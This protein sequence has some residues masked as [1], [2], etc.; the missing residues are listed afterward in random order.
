LD[1][2]LRTTTA[3][4]AAVVTAAQAPTNLTTVFY[5]NSSVRVSFTLPRNYYSSTYYYQLNTSAAGVTTSASGQSAALTT[6]NLS[7][8]TSYT[9][10]IGVYLDGS[11]R[12]TTA[13]AAT[14]TTT[15]QAASNLTA[16][17]YD[18]SS[19]RVSF[20]LPRNS[21]TTSYYYQLNAITSGVTTTA[22]GQ[23]ALLTATNLSGNTSYTYTVGV[24]L[25][26]ALRATTAGSA[27]IITAVQPA[28][29]LA[30]SSY[31]SSSVSVSFNLPRN[32]YTTSYYYQLNTTAAGITTSA[33]GQSAALTTTNLSGN[34]SY[35]YTVGV[36]L[37][38]ALRTTTA[39]AAAVTTAAQPA[40]NLSTTFYDSSA[41]TIAFSLPR[42]SY[43]STYY[44]QL[45]TVLY[46]VTQSASGQTTPIT[47]YGLSGNA[48]Y[49]CYV[50]TYLD[51]SLKATS[52][53]TSVT[54]NAQS[55]TN[56]T[57][58]FTDSSSIQFT[59]TLPRNNYTST[60]YYQLNATTSGVTTS[61][62]GQTSPL[63]VKGLTDG[64]T[65]TCNILTYL[66]GTLKTTSNT[67]YITT[68]SS[69]NSFSGLVTAVV[70]YSAK[71]MF[72]NII[73]VTVKY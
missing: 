53:S 19:V 57:N 24:Y 6:T 41:I 5:D 4:S 17:F 36:Y 30:T 29:N 1:G 64:T 67:Y 20:T 7:G 39:G 2:V 58:S 44:Y 37:D 66:D 16:T 33:S 10:T 70:T 25:D 35:T 11:L 9:Y 68:T 46:G 43:T 8:N 26:G 12:A 21:Y 61:V 63:F 56:I 3:G 15:A 49:T 31:D 23:A 28:T 45:N 55:P 27:A 62:S 69:S 52:Y 71:T 38:G 73:M 72:N 51:G 59:F 50:L 32:S 65:Y 48:L 14:V 54:T 13:G 60:Y 47:I 22:S 34:T 18:S 42:N 40:T